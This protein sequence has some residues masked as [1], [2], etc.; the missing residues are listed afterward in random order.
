MREK[1]DPHTVEVLTKIFKSQV[2]RRAVHIH[3]T[4]GYLRVAGGEEEFREAER[5]GGAK[6]RPELMESSRK[7]TFPFP[8]LR[9]DAS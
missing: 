1:G 9:L 8:Y 5:H 2:L 6:V 4:F 3:I 7:L